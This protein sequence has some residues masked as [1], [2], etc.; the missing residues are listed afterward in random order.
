MSVKLFKA[1]DYDKFF[2]KKMMIDAYDDDALLHTGGDYFNDNAD[3]F[4]EEIIKEGNDFYLIEK[5]NKIIGALS[6]KNN[7]ILSI[8][9][10]PFLHNFGYGKKVMELI[11]EIY[12]KDFIVRI[13]SYSNRLYH[14]FSKCSFKVLNGETLNYEEYII[15][16]K[17]YE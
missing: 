17:K 7:E 9:I 8:F 10:D 15:M 11:D 14:F 3:D 4:F 13:P 6:I 2:I 1:Q 12:K 5:G 16:E